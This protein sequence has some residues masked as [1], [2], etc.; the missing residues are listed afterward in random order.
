VFVVVSLSVVRKSRNGYAKHTNHTKKDY[1]LIVP[2]Q[3]LRE[4]EATKRMFN[5]VLGSI[6]AI[7]LLV[8]GIGIMNI[9]LAT[10]TERTH[11]ITPLSPPFTPLRSGPVQGRLQGPPAKSK[12][13]AVIPHGGET[14]SPCFRPLL[15]NFLSKVFSSSPVLPA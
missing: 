8:G 3:L 4:A 2:L 11:E 6:A 1:E 9:M 13:L 15:R 14:R 12:F 7:S 10:V 5:I